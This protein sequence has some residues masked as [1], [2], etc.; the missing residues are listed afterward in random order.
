M[1]P[2]SFIP[3][4][5]WFV[6]SFTHTFPFLRDRLLLHLFLRL[7]HRFIHLSPPSFP[8]SL[9]RPFPPPSSVLTITDLEA[10]SPVWTRPGRRQPR[11]HD[12]LETSPGPRLGDQWWGVKVTSYLLSG[13]SLGICPPSWAR[14]SPSSS[15]SW[16]DLDT[17]FR[18]VFEPPR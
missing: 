7:I 18:D 8:R 13:L 1:G 15:S 16:K 11:V 9:T 12:A 14:P 3:G 10:Q 5:H 6:H 4:S 2:A 17:Q